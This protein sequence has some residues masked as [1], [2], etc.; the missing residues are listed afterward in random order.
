MILSVLEA[1]RKA[2]CAARRDV[3]LLEAGET[4]EGTAR[5]ETSVG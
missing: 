4:L 2:G 3:A 1:S 5:R